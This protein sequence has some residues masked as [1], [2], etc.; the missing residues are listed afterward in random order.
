MWVRYVYTD[1]AKIRFPINH[2]DNKNQEYV[3]IVRSSE[4]YLFNYANNQIS[5]NHIMHYSKSGK[6]IFNFESRTKWTDI[7]PDSFNAILLNKIL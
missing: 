2:G 4:M 6:V 7:I 3:Y 1:D 5:I